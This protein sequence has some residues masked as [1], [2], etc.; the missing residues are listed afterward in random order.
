MKSGTYKA[1]WPSI[2]K[3][4]QQTQMSTQTC[5]QARYDPPAPLAA[6]TQDGYRATK[7]VRA[8]GSRWAAYANDMF[9]FAHTRIQSYIG[10][11]RLK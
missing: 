4:C 7:R 9:E 8:R 3:R 5:K 6:W 10:M 11:I 1:M 2:E